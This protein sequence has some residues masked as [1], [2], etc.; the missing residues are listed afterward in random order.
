MLLVFRIYGMSNHDSRYK[1]KKDLPVVS[2]LVTTPSINANEDI[3][4]DSNGK[5]YVC[6]GW[7]SPNSLYKIESESN[8]KELL[9]I[10]STALSITEDNKGNMYVTDKEKLIKISTNGNIDTLVNQRVGGG[11]IADKKGDLYTID[12]YNQMMKKISQQGKVE[13]FITSSL[14]NGPTGIAYNDDKDE[15]YVGNWNDGKILLVN[16]N[17]NVS[18]IIDTTGEIGRMTFGNNHIYVTSNSEH[19][20]YEIS[21]NGTITK[22][23]GNGNKGETDGDAFMATFSNPNGIGISPDGNVL[24]VSSRE[25]G[26]RKIEL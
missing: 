19:L 12:F 20:I 7:R 6:G 14:F 16:K 22:T 25:G 21:L 18:E 10:M 3:I 8:V 26:I 11:I 15:I 13:T 5:I 4:V 2:T 23:I 9:N 1:N 17:G 24:Y